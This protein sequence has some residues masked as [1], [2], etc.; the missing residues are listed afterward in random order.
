MD[1]K[2]EFRIYC[3]S[4]K[5]GKK[6]KV[7]D[8]DNPGIYNIFKKLAIQ[9]YDVG[10]RK[11]S[12]N[13]IFEYIRWYMSVERRYK[14]YKM[15]NNYRAYYARKLMAEDSRFHDFFEIREKKQK[16]KDNTKIVLKYVRVKKGKK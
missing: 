15:N 12:S 10:H 9:A 2:K 14:T 11:Y 16:Q 1:Y 4:N 7:F 13:G 5:T 8:K 3:F 6:A